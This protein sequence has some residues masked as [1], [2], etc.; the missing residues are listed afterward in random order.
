MKNISRELAKH[1]YEV[2]FGDNWTASNLKAHLEDVNIK[3]A[4]KKIE[5]YNT[6]LALTY[7]IYYY[8]KVT[9]EVLDGQ[10]LNAHDKYSYTHPQITSEKAWQAFLKKVFQEANQFSLSVASLKDEQLWLFI[11][12]EKYGT[13]YRNIQGIIEHA[14]YHLGQIV[15]LKKMLNKQLL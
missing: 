3:V 12:E 9:Q 5:G 11:D 1:I 6:I 2:F 13:Y 15:I 7:H 8:L 10:P 14:H 4:T